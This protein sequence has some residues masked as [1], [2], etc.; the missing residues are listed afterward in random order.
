MSRTTIG[1]IELKRLREC[2]R[3]VELIEELCAEPFMTITFHSDDASMPG[4]DCLIMIEGSRPAQPE[5][6]RG[7]DLK[8][9][10]EEYYGRSLVECLERAVAA[11][12][13]RDE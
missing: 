2:S 5:P 10:Q 7:E 1:G 9:F 3:I 12:K 11:K 6:G 4:H 13:A 8:E